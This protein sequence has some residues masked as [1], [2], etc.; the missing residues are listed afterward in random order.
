ML[1]G[2]LE[3]LHLPGGVFPEFTRPAVWLFV[4]NFKDATR[5]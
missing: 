3:L 1:S 5:E 4:M 2:R